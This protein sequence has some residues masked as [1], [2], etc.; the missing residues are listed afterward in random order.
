[1]TKCKIYGL[2]GLMK[3]KRIKDHFKIRTC[4]IEL[5]NYIKSA[6]KTDLTTF[7]IT[8]MVMRCPKTSREI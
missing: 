5:I 2:I 3:K 8:F 1:M 6:E 4:V 7:L